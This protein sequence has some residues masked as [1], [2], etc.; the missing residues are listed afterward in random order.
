MCTSVIP[1]LLGLARSLGRTS[2]DETPL[3]SHIF[4]R[5]ST[6][7]GSQPQRDSENTGQSPRRSFTKFRPIIPKGMSKSI[8]KSPNLQKSPLA[9]CD[10]IDGRRSRSKSPSP[11]SDFAENLES[12]TDDTVDPTSHYF[13]VVGS[14][15]VRKRAFTQQIKVKTRL[16]KF[17][18]GDLQVLFNQ[19]NR[20]DNSLTS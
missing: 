3:L 20:G 6:S 4:S 11:G 8:L 2:D 14:S 19:V 5:E 1:V 13:N 16:I 7:A 17:S 18:S 10:M 12:W 9:S 15:F